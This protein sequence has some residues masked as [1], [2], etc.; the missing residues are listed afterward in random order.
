MRTSGATREADDPGVSEEAVSA[1]ELHCTN[2]SN[3]T[4]AHTTSDV[5]R[6]CN[7]RLYAAKRLVDSIQLELQEKV[8]K[9]QQLEQ[10]L[11]DMK[12]I[13]VDHVD[14]DQDL[15][16][17]T[18]HS[19]GGATFT[20]STQPLPEGSDGSRQHYSMQQLVEL[21]SLIEGLRHGFQDV[22]FVIMPPLF[23]NL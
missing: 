1:V 6:L 22:S 7:K 20:N 14:D 21:Q 2:G 8:E 5:V 9:V 18:T 10:Q 11:A 3:T 16:Q 13:M 19:Y 23:I 4:A 15:E 12:M 17:C